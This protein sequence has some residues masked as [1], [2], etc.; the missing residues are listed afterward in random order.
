MVDNLTKKRIGTAIESERE[1]QGVEIETLADVVEL[2][3]RSV[4]D[5]ERGKSAPS[6]CTMIDIS[7]AL[8]KPAH[9]ILEDANV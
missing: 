4:R 8:A 3:P 9:Q 2:T 1:R 5:I 7:R 6:M